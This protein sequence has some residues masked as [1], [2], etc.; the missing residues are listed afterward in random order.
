M[1]VARALMS[2]DYFRYGI[3]RPKTITEVHSSSERPAINLDT[4]WRDC[5]SFRLKGLQVQRKF[6]PDGIQAGKQL[7]P[8]F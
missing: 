4:R 2:V 3:M 8:A 1:A 7:P 6:K 5:W